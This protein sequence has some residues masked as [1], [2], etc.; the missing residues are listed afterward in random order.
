MLIHPLPLEGAALIEAEPFQD[1]R[2]LFARFFCTRE[3]SQIFGERQIVNVNFSR[4]HPSGA[5]RGMHFQRPPH[6]EMKLVRC[7]RGSVF[8]VIVDLRPESPAFLKW[9]GEILSAVNM[10][11]LCV[12]EGFAHG[13]QALEPDSEVLY[14]TT[15]FYAPKAEAGLR[16]DDPAV[17]I[18]WP[19]EVTEI[20][21]RDASHPFLDLDRRFSE[22]T[23]ANLGAL[24]PLGNQEQL[25]PGEEA[26]TGNLASLASD[27]PWLWLP[28]PKSTS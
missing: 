26:E 19:L 23:E 5:M 10:K 17:G 13:F 28:E 24:N 6:Q 12:P 20:S 7:L 16:Y 3:L 21:Q 11:M 15:A 18:E 14:L 27:S 25:N 22:T 9:H 8:D 4:T 2:G 1:H